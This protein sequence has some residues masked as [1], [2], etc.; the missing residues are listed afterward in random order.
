MSQSRLLLEAQFGTRL[1]ALSAAMERGDEAS[2]YTMLDDMLHSRR[3]ALFGELR[4]LTCNL[5]VAL[6]RFR[7]D[8]RLA[9]IAEKDMPDARQRLAHVLKMT[10][11]AAHRTMD[12]VDQ[13]GP[14]A[15]RT[16][17][18]AA[19]LASQWA[20]FRARKISTRDFRELLEKM[21][22]FLPT[23]QA[24]AELVR[25]NLSE[26]L[27]TQGYQDLTGQIIRGVMQ[28]VQELEI[29]LVDLTRLSGQAD[30]AREQKAN[31]GFGPVVP[32]VTK[33]EV[34]SGQQDVDALLSGLGV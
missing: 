26:V 10:D 21:D 18:A 33:G 31:Q 9:D 25:R 30:E 20:S 12:L 8:S 34:A 22:A 14:P 11:E 32:G 6:D 13:S 17:K 16:S 5:Q 1:Q 19:L 29:A 27:L 2:F 28:L 24:D 4:E 15:E 3:P 7:V 23:V